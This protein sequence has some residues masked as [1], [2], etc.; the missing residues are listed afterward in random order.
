MED[1]KVQL[2]NS[3]IKTLTTS[4]MVNGVSSA[5][6]GMLTVKDAFENGTNI[7]TLMRV[8]RAKGRAL[9]LQGLNDLILF[10]DAKKRFRMLMK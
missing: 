5:T 6:V 8:E 7:R 10:M 3:H 4:L 2:L 9:M 1:N